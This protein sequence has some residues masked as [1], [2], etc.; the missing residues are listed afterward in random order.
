MVTLASGQESKEVELDLECITDPSAKS[1]AGD[2]KKERVSKDSFKVRIC[3]IKFD[4]TSFSLYCS[5]EVIS[6]VKEEHIEVTYKPQS[7]LK[8]T[9]N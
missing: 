7:N 5:H 3:N 8:I 6:F 9:T 1:F 4:S 2:C